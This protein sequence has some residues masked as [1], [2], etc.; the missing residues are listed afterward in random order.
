MRKLKHSDSF[1]EPPNVGG[2]TGAGTPYLI[3]QNFLG[4]R[5]YIRQALWADGYRSSRFEVWGVMIDSE[6]DEGG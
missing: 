6:L 2:H 4:S 3:W 1:F 5:V